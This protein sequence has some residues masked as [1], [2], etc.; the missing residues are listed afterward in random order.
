MESSVVLVDL[1]IYKWKNIKSGFFTKN[2]EVQDFY[3]ELKQRQMEME[4]KARQQQ[5]LA[6]KQEELELQRKMFTF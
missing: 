5:K 3:L 6:Q 1:L 2:K 4:E